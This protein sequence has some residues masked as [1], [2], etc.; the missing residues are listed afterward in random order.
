MSMSSAPS[1]LEPASSRIL[2]PAKKRGRPS[3][4]DVE[5]RQTESMARKEISPAVE[6]QP[7]LEN[8]SRAI[9]LVARMETPL[10][11]PLKRN[12]TLTGSAGDER[13]IRPF[14]QTVEKALISNISET[15]E[16]KGTRITS[17]PEKALL[18]IQQ[19]SP[20][21]PGSSLRSSTLAS[22]IEASS[23]PKNLPSLDFDRAK[24]LRVRRP[25]NS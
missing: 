18:P 20:I 8:G 9:E 13:R 4:A 12:R 2:F 11:T 15:L 21:N 25:T 19:L 3:K 16:P 22:E 10:S 7:P 23:P 6:P 14:P 24:K 5:R 1:S 17:H